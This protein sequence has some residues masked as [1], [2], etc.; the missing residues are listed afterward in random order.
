MIELPTIRTLLGDRDVVICAGGGGIPVTRADD[1]Q[2]TGA[3]AVIDK[4]LG[5]SPLA[6]DLRADA[7][8][9]LTDV[10]NVEVGF[11]TAAAKPIGHTTPAALR[12]QSFPDGSMGPKVEAACRFVEATG[13]PAMIGR[14][15]DAAE[16]LP[17]TCGTVVEPSDYPTALASLSAV[18]LSRTLT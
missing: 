5:A 8:L 13:K 4:D 7:L 17:G 6:R 1:G 2:L 15:A 11:G 9:I 18:R 3:E 10:T 14:L 16:L 12:A